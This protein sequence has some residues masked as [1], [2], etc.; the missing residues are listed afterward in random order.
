[1]G[2]IL[3]FSLSLVV[4]G[5]LIFLLVF[6][7]I[8]L[9]DLECD[10]LNAQECCGRLN[11]WNIP[12][13]WSQLTLFIMLVL[14]GHIGLVAFNI[15][16]CAWLVR[17]FHFIKRGNIGEYDPAEIHN[18]GQLRRHMIYVSLHLGWQM[19]SFFVYLYCL[20]DAVMQEEVIL[21]AED[22]VT[23]LNKPVQTKYYE[24]PASHDHPARDYDF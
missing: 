9:S 4:T 23:V 18:A 21:P 15:P 19:V 22:D 1:M 2:D 10:Y 12:K 20:L 8:T 7:I 24:P 3:L 16:I 17:Q 6:F 13:L 11:F 14:S 5:A